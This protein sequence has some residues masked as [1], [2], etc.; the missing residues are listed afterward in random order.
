MPEFFYEVCMF[1][2]CGGRCSSHSVE[3]QL[4]STVHCNLTVGLNACS[5]VYL[6][7][8]DS[9]VER[10]W[11]S[12]IMAACIMRH[13]GPLLRCC[14]A[15]LPHRPVRP[16][17]CVWS[18]SVWQMMT[19]HSQTGSSVLLRPP[20]PESQDSLVCSSS[21]FRQNTRRSRGAVNQLTVTSWPD[22]MSFLP[23]EA[24][25]SDLN[26]LRDNRTLLI[27]T[28]TSLGLELGA[29]AMSLPYLSPPSLISLLCSSVF[30]SS[31][32]SPRLPSLVLQ[33]RSGTDR[34]RPNCDMCSWVVL[35]N[36]HS[37]KMRIE[38]VG[39]V[40]P[41]QRYKNYWLKTIIHGKPE[42]KG[43]VG[44]AGGGAEQR[45][46]NVEVQEVTLPRSHI[47]ACLLLD[48]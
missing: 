14:L 45:K 32:Q 33:Q 11:M 17:E 29:A 5:S 3:G 47:K 38:L 10:G 23:A 13:F 25:V 43:C 27:P 20:S 41:S 35:P 37:C 44:G 1:S 24:V 7:P 21:S 19:D 31:H 40:V 48:N 28:G 6:L 42:R 30:S 39:P 26:H 18:P 9:K 12:Y 15:C 34:Q 22:W 36:S 4:R 2:L 46:G 16:L 8:N